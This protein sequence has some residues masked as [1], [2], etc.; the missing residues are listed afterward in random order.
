MKLSEFNMIHRDGEETIF[1]NT[2]SGAVIG[3][4][5]DYMGK[6]TRVLEGE[7]RGA[8]DLL[9]EM[10]RTGMLVPDDCDE[11]RELLLE[12]GIARFSSDH[13]GL[14]I[15]PTLAC[16]FRCPYCYEKG[17]RKTVMSDET[18]GRVIASGLLESHG[19]CA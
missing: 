5:E 13:L 16:N 1:H 11:R 2:K 6:L 17:Q 10:S 3:L 19:Y 4:D 12:S 15:A 18:A 7:S 9:E 8:E 14:T